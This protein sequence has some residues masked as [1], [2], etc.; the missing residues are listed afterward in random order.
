LNHECMLFAFW[1]GKFCCVTHYICNFFFVLFC[2]SPSLLWDDVY[3]T[4][5]DL[6]SS[7]STREIYIYIYIYMLEIEK[8]SVSSPSLSSY[9]F[10]LE[11]FLL[12]M[13]MYKQQNYQ[14]DPSLYSYTINGHYGC[15]HIGYWVLDWPIFYTYI[16]VASS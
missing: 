16:V 11:I 4:D 13:N 3:F 5:C 10:W 7:Q 8:F 12:S 1:Q 9:F 6:C 2:F 14:F 15:L